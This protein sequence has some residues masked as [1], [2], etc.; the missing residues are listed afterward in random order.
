MDVQNEDHLQGFYDH[1]EIRNPIDFEGKASVN[2]FAISSPFW[3]GQ[4][5]T[6][7]LTQSGTFGTYFKCNSILPTTLQEISQHLV[8]IWNQIVQESPN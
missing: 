2:T 7:T 6:R 1:V 8:Q 4:L 5:A 3:R